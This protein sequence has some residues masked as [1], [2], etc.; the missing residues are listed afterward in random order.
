MNIRLI[1]KKYI[2]LILIVIST[3]FFFGYL[4][5][6][7]NF[8]ARKGSSDL[9]KPIRKNNASFTPAYGGT[10]IWG[11]RQKPTII[12]PVLLTQSISVNLSNIIFNRLLRINARGDIEP[13][14]AYQWIIS[15]D[16]LIYTFMLREGVKFHD[17]VEFTSRD[18]KFTFDQIL[19]EKNNSPHRSLFVSVNTIEIVNKY[20]CRFILKEPFQSFLYEIADR[21]IIPFHLLKA[22]NLAD[23]SFNYNPVGTGPFRFESWDRKTDQIEVSY[24]SDYFEG[25]PYLDK[26]IVRIYPGSVDHWSAIMRE[27]IDLMLF[28]DQDDYRIV[29]KDP[30]FKTYEIVWNNYCAIAYDVNDF[31]L[32]DLKMR[33]AIASSLDIDGILNLI[34]IGGTRSVGPFHEKSI[35]FNKEIKPLAYDPLG[36][37]I[38]LMHMGWIDTN[39][40]GILE[41]GGRDLEIKMLVDER[42]DIYKKMAKLIRQQLSEIGIKIIIQMYKNEG[43]LTKK[44]LEEKNPQ[45]WLRFYKGFGLDPFE[46]TRSWYSLSKEYARVWNYKNE[47]VDQLFEEGMVVSDIRRRSEIYKKIHKIVYEDQPVC[48]LFFLETYHVVSNKF[49]NSDDFF[50][51][52]MPAYTIKDWYYEN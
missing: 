24:N 34:S 45:A 7:K 17:G 19:D 13:D 9:K 28:V 6:K 4:E 29:K 22:E 47:E 10:L 44:Y 25:R 39:G 5:N 20:M 41:K 37:K 21:E 11:A 27:D 48:F 35:G 49:K 32:K 26:I 36:A 50:S 8:D 16:G 51:D 18:V 40:D 46:S 31:I 12:N 15:D 14:L 42:S 33:K 3:G 43:E 38:D 1:K 23:T 30:S 52:Y 2:L